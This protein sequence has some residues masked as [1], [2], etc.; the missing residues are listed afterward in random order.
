MYSTSLLSSHRMAIML[1]GWLTV[2][3]TPACVGATPPRPDI[4]VIV[5]DDLGYRDLGSYGNKIATP[6]LDRL[7]AGG[8]QLTCL[9]PTKF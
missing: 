7:A 2:V 9:T 1:V 5:A 4:L 3:G 8:V 6:N